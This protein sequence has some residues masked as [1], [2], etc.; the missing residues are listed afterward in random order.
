[1]GL[2][3]RLFTVKKLDS[4]VMH[5]EKR[6]SPE[7]PK[8]QALLKKRLP[9]DVKEQIQ[10]DIQKIKA[11]DYG[12][13]QVRFTLSQSYMPM[14][15]LHD[16][17]L[18][19]ENF[20]AQI[21]FLVITRKLILVI[22]CKNYA[23]DVRIDKNGQFI[24]IRD[25][26]K[27]GFSDPTEQ[28]RRHA[29]MICRLRP[30][31]KKRCVPLV[32]FT[33]EKSILRLNTAPESIKNQVLKSDKL[34]NHIRT[35]HE[36]M[37]VSELSDSEMKKYADFFLHLHTENPVDYTAKYQ[38]YLTPPKAKTPQ[39]SELSCPHCKKPVRKGAYG[40]YCSGK[41][42]MKIDKVYG[43]LLTDKQ[44]SALLNGKSVKCQTKSGMTSVLPEIEKNSYQGTVSFQWKTKR[45]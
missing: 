13:K 36:T 2:F 11:G 29:D 6:P 19:Q 33:N 9:A 21:D 20:T 14:Y 15:I 28:N 42:G 25:G 7:L 3:N 40:W 31:L 26:A 10:Q 18:K 12:E 24:L 16:V 39:K 35:L 34:V 1:M 5:K 27:Q 45:L 44:V 41:C 4:P 17:Y 38:K 8:L 22:E 37:H 30:E 23:S 43:T 32:V